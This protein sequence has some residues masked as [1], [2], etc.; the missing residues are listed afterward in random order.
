[1]AITYFSELNE[2]EVSLLAKAP[3]LVTVLVAGADQEIDKK[4]INWA[5]KL[6]NFRTFTA[7]EK[8]HDYYEL[9]NADFEET[10]NQL[11][12]E[13]TAESGQAAVNEQLSLLKPI[14][15]KVDDDYAILLKESL[16]SMAKHVAKASGGFLGMGTIDGN[17]EKVLSLDM[18]D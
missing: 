13:W 17:E 10:L 12:S 3:A 1:M 2:E 6:V 7:D 8:L 11:V 15:A 18:L 9:V 5:N 14:L 4:E 16:R